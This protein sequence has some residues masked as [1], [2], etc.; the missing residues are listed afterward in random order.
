MPAKL[1]AH[2]RQQWMGALA[3]FLVLTGGVAYAADT[4]FSADIV[5]G[6]VKSVDIGNNQVRS[7]DVRDDGLADGGLAADD[8]QPDAVGSSEIAADSVG[9]SEVVSNIVGADE[10][11]SVHE[12]FGDIT[13][14]V[15]GTA[16]DGIYATSVSSVSC[17]AGEDL[18]SVSID[19]TDLAGHGE[20][21]TSGVDSIS[22]GEPDAATVRVAYDGGAG[23]A[24]YRAVAPCLS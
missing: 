13:N 21:V 17:G 9:S 11:E 1:L 23:P 6:E 20:V 12:H 7:A 16:H 22:R 14:V 2:L 15:D 10:L 24:K 3:L 5:N 8:L 18:L 4:V 19:W